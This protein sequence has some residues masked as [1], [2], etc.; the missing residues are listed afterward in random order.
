MYPIDELWSQRMDAE[1]AKGHLGAKLAFTR[2]SFNYFIS[3]AVFAYIVEAVHLVAREGWKLLALY[4]FDPDSGLWEHRAGVPDRGAGLG[5]LTAM[6]DGA[7][8]RFATAPESALAGQLDA[9]RKII[10]AAD[11]L[12]PTGPVHDPALSDDFERI[13]WFPLPGEGLAQLHAARA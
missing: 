3:E 1:V 7:T 13:R 5:D 12:A 9:A 10:A 4:R 2:L 6:L 8:P 11:A